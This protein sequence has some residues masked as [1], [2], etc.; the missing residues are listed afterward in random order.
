MKRILILLTTGLL[1]LPVTQA[2]R[3]DLKFQKKIAE[4]VWNTHPDL[5]NPQREIP[6]S[7]RERFSAVVIGQLDFMDA[8]YKAYQDMRGT[9]TRTN[10]N[11]FTRRMV[12]ILDQKGV[13][14]FS[15]HEFGEKGSL[16][17]RFRRSIAEVKRTFGARVHKPDGTVQDVDMANAFAI[18]KGKGEETVGYKIDIPGLQ[19]EDVLEYFTY[20]EDFAR[21]YDLPAMRIVIADKYP[22][23]ESVIDATFDPK[24]T[25]EFRGYNGAPDLAC[26]V[27]DKGRNTATLHLGY[28]GPLTD[29]HYVNKTRELPFYDF[30]ILNNTSPYRFYPKYMRGGGLYQNPLAG[31]IFR[32]ISLTI[33]ASNYETSKLPGKVRKVIKNYRNTHPDASPEELTGMAWTA[34]NYINMTD[35]DANASDYWLALMM[36]DILRKE[37]LN[38][39]AGVAF[40]NPANDVPTGEIIHWR[41][42]E[43]G[44]LAG[45]RLYLTTELN[46]YLPSDMPPLFQGQLAASYP[47]DREKLWNFTMPTLITVPLSKAGENKF[48]VTSTITL[49]EDN[50][51]TVAN[52][53]TLTGAMKYLA[54]G[55]TN[56]NEWASAQEEYLGIE[57]GKRYK[58]KN[59]D[60]A[61]RAE[62]ISDAVKSIYTDIY[63]GEDYSLSDISVSARGITPDAPDVK[64]SFTSKIPEAYTSSPDEKIVKIGNF[65]GRQDKLDTSERER[66]TNISMTAA[67]QDNYNV[68]LNVPEGYE[69]DDESIAALTRNVSTPIGMF[70]A[71]AKKSDDGRKVTVATRF[72]INKPLL[73]AEA[74]PHI[75]TL[76]DARSDFNHSLLILK[77][78]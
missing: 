18:T 46:Q 45:D 63:S 35:K 49:G 36:C 51:A 33:A 29:R 44:M 26:G 21:E 72:R 14:D 76:T 10:R 17:T 8:E 62:D 12:K 75:Q 48:S 71:S 43:F 5:F 52:D 66:S 4:K 22:A 61:K 42:P 50:D 53:V 74:W 40:I 2:Q 56:F 11:Y 73:P 16:K 13:E 3:A 27:N 37:K 20:T 69:A 77:K 19:P 32:D 28:V 60:E 68:V 6:D 64:F 31:T 59:P 47:G 23:L 25:V 78:K 70:V 39:N 57:A 34:A 41:Q 15:K 38:D 58:P 24:L 1:M 30:Y 65:T 9:E 7:L 54:E 55:L 67:S